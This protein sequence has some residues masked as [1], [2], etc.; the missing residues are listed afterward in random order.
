MFYPAQ[1]PRTGGA[2]AHHSVIPIAWHQVAGASRLGDGT[3]PPR[4]PVC[5]DFLNDSGTDSYNMRKPARSNLQ[6]GLV[7]E[8]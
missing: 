8:R 5:T 6:I 7:E 4:Q 2:M 3:E 1:Q